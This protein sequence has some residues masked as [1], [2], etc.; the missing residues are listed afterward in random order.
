MVN[1]S[2]QDSEKTLI[3]Q[4]AEAIGVLEQRAAVGWSGHAGQLAHAFQPVEKG[5]GNAVVLL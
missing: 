4:G 1:D 2:R 5:I 3:N